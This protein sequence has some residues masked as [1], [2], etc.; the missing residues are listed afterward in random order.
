MIEHFENN[1]AAKCKLQEI[2]REI[3]IEGYSTVHENL[4][5][6]FDLKAKE[7]Q[8]FFQMKTLKQNNEAI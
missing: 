1:M 3:V 8:F 6:I 7:D 5:G 2:E 4:S